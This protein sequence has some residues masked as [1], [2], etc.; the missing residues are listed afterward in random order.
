MCDDWYMHKI[1][2]SQDFVD[3]MAHVFT[4]VIADEPCWCCAQFLDRSVEEF[5]HEHRRICSDIQGLYTRK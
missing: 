5:S 3:H 4:S 1:H 2:I